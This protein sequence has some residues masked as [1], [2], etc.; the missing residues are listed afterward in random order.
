MYDKF[1]FQLTPKA[2]AAQN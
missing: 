2:K 1:H